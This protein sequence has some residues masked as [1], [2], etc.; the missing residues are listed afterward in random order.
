WKFQVW[1]LWGRK[2][3]YDAAL[4]L[5]QKAESRDPMNR[6]YWVAEARLEAAFARVL[7]LPAWTPTL[8]VSTPWGPFLNIQLPPQPAG[9]YVLAFQRPAYTKA[10]TA[11]RLALENA[12]KAL[13]EAARLGP[14]QPQAQFQ[15]VAALQAANHIEEAE[16]A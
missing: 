8:A 16:R 1:Q 7:Q 15:F 13:R 11:G 4:R 3:D 5:T 12:T 14:T 6:E 2:A 10:G 9:A